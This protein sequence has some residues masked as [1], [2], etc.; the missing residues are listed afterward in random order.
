[1]GSSGY[2]LEDGGGREGGKTQRIAYLKLQTMSANA[3]GGKDERGMGGPWDPGKEWPPEQPDIRGHE[4]C[5]KK[6]KIS[7]KK[8][9]PTVGKRGGLKGDQ[10]GVMMTKL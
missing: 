8:K 5:G 1:L 4:K 2:L 7:R 3:S 6:K 9:T 10:I